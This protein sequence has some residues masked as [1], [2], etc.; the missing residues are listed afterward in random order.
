M[1]DHVYYHNDDVSSSLIARCIQKHVRGRVL[2]V[3]AGVGHVTQELTKISTSVMALE[4]NRHL[5]AELEARISHIQ[6]A[7]AHNCDTGDFLLETSNSESFDTVVYFNVLEHIEDDSQEL[8]RASR[9]L[10]NNGQIVVLVPAHQWLYSSIDRLTGHYRRYSRK[11][12]IALV[13]KH[14]V[15]VNV[16]YFDTA[17]LLPYLIIYR[18]LRSK[19]VSG[20]NARIYSQVILRISYVIFRIF[21]GLIIGKNLIITARC[22]K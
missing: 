7:T 17:G 3:G 14:F 20:V 13:Q 11:S 21:G 2:E 22:S 19:K 10:V 5:H 1:S 12:A 4:P 15:D 6:N 8:E 9:L 16:R 18:I